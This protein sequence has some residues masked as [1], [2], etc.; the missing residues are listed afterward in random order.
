MFVVDL[1][2][3]CHKSTRVS[4]PPLVPARGTK[5]Y[6]CPLRVPGGLG[7]STRLLDNDR[8]VHV[9]MDCTIQV[10]GACCI[11][12]TNRGAVVPVVLL[13]DSW[14]TGFYCWFGGTIDPRTIDDDVC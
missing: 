4:Q 5:M 7:V 13:V 11:E 10:K 1:R 2:A 9:L 14:G 3:V 6:W 12:W 8:Q